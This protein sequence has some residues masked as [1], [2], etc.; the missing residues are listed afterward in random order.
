MRRRRVH[1]GH[2]DDRQLN[3]HPRARRVRTEGYAAWTAIV[4]APV[5]LRSRGRSGDLWIGRFMSTKPPA[6]SLARASVESELRVGSHRARTGTRSMGGHTL[7]LPSITSTIL[8]G[9]YG[10]A[11]G[12]LYAPARRGWLS[13]EARARWLTLV[14]AAGGREQR[15]RDDESF[16]VSR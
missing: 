3:R 11:R 14:G 16:S 9:C 4:L 1:R 12:S 15:N 10:R 6:R 2:R 8:E 5:S 7:I 13:N